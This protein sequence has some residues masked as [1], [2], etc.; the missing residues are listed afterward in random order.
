MLSFHANELGS[1]FALGPEQ[2]FLLTLRAAGSRP[3][4]KIAFSD[5]FDTDRNNLVDAYE[6]LIAMAVL[7]RMG[8]EETVGFAFNLFD[9]NQSHTL[10]ADE[11]TMLLHTFVG[12]ECEPVWTVPEPETSPYD[13]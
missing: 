11:C 1:A 6:V 4:S 10:S 2:F 9:Y 7:S 13:V 8:L 12:D 3:L 5:V